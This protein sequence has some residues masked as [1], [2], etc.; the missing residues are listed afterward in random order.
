M[1]VLGLRNYLLSAVLAASVF[2]VTPVALAVDLNQSS[3]FQITN[4]QAG[5]IAGVTPTNATLKR[6]AVPPVSP[7]MIRG[8]FTTNGDG[9][10]AY[11]NY[12]TSACSL[13]SGLGDNG[14]QVKPNAG[15]GCWLADFSRMRP[16]PV[17]WGAIGDGRTDDTAAVQ[18]AINGAATANLP[19]YFDAVHLYNI[20]RSLIIAAPVDLEGASGNFG[21]GVELPS[22]DCPWG[23][24]TNNTGIDM[25]DATAF[26]ADDPTSVHRD[27]AEYIANQR[28]GHSSDLLQA[29]ADHRRL[30]H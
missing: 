20:T 8:G 6:I 22:T 23:L 18:A 14:S 27:V 13:N 5:H 12:N 1:D 21:Y 28:L 19:L 10:W 3:H 16:N 25:L 15:G 24:K 4:G 17:I 9:G 11:Y 29:V 26:S 7:Q 2:V 30:C